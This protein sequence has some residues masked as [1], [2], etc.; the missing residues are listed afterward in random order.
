[1]TLVR[2]IQVAIATLG[3]IAMS[4]PAAACRSGRDCDGSALEDQR[5]SRLADVAAQPEAEIS[6]T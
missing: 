2:K 4:H 5:D 6:R 3:L 1:M